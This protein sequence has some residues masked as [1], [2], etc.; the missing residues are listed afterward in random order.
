MSDG[1]VVVCGI[2]GAGKSYFARKFIENLENLGPNLY[3]VAGM[4]GR[5]RSASGTEARSS[6]VAMQPGLMQPRIAETVSKMVPTNGRILSI[7]R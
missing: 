7:M 6:Q 1:I 5:A 3:L 2:P 4:N